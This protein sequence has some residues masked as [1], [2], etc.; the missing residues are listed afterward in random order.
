MCSILFSSRNIDDLD[1]VNERIQKRGPDYTGLYNHK[2]ELLA[3][4]KLSQPT[5]K[6]EATTLQGQV[7]LDF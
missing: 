7:K 3:I 5:R 4:A 2:N 6:D 1:F